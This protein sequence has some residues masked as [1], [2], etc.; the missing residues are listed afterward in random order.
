MRNE[1][2]D[3]VA[4]KSKERYIYKCILYIIGGFFGRG[5]VRVGGCGF[6]G[7]DAHIVPCIKT[8]SV[9]CFANAT[10][11]EREAAKV[12]WGFV[13]TGLPDGPPCVARNR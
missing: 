7:D 6:V 12:G 10:S 13:G 4:E 2:W 9:I 5:M 1:K 8:P 3:E 11:L